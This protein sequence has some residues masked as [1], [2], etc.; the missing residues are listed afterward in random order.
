MYAVLNPAMSSVC[1]QAKRDN[2]TNSC[3]DIHA[4]YC[5]YYKEKCDMLICIAAGC[6]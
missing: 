5:S 6:A 3:T 1:T 2:D 4:A